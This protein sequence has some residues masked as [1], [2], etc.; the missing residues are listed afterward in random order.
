[1]K[2]LLSNM[3]RFCDKKL[4]KLDS[5]CQNVD[6]IPL[7]SITFYSIFFVRLNFNPLPNFGGSIL[8]IPNV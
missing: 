2:W 4:T 3:N 6:L 8:K 1:M 7:Q 5:G